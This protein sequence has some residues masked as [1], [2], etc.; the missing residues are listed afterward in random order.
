[1]NKATAMYDAKTQPTDASV[2][3]YLAAIDDAQRRQDCHDLVALMAQATG[4]E[5]R[6]WGPSIV[7]FDRYHYRYASGHQGESCMVGFA[8]RKGDISVYLLPGLDG[9]ETQ[10]LMARLGRHRAGK[11]CVYI[12]RLS[13]ISLPVLQAL[14]E[15]SVAQTRRRHPDPPA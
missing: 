15:A 4:C 12:R 5:A 1:M 6:M 3:A 13:D 14:V 10:A 9:P 11:A 8:A 7:G 2:Q